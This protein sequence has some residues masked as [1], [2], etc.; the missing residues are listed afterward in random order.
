MYLVHG[1]EDLQR[2]QFSRADPIP[3]TTGECAGCRGPARVYGPKGRQFCAACESAASRKD[4]KAPL[5]P[6]RRLIPGPREPEPGWKA[7]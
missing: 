5:Q 7:C 3:L 6:C 1:R 4:R 2:V